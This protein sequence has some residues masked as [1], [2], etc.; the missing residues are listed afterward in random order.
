VQSPHPVLP[1]GVAPR[2]VACG[3][4]ITLFLS[5]C[6]MPSVAASM[7]L[8]PRHEGVHAVPDLPHS[9]IAFPGAGVG[10]RGWFFP[11][12]GCDS[13]RGCRERRGVV[14][15]LH[16][17]SQNR[18]AGLEVAR[19]LVPLGYDV[20]AYDSRAHGES[21]GR[22]S[23]FGY[24]ERLDVSHA[25]DFLAADRVVVIGVSMGA[26]VALQAAAED[27]RIVGVVAVSSFASMERVVRE[28]LPGFVPYGEVQEVFREV[29]RRSGIRVKSVDVVQAAQRIDAPVLVMHGMEDRFVLPDHSLRIYHAL[30]GPKELVLVDGARHADVLALDFS[31]RRIEE[32]LRTAGP[33]GTEILAERSASGVLP[34]RGVDEPDRGARA[35]RRPP[36]RDVQGCGRN[37]HRRSQD[38]C[39]LDALGEDARPERAKV[40][41]VEP[42]LPRDGRGAAIGCDLKRGGV[43][44]A[45]HGQELRAA[46][47]RCALH[48]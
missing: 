28:R 23:T 33:R 45:E 44:S 27:P 17:R 35:S 1:R 48:P 4:L 24:Y 12:A 5:G 29:E 21:G 16:G 14:I 20:L 25:I 10:I 13:G 32:W 26:A 31:W 7:I 40:R 3:L 42:E 39:D 47:R 30:Q 34:Q 36:T 22:Y 43:E 2:A 15:F 11:A 41:Q 19:R 9:E 6:V 18:E 46:P 37:L 8:E 38:W